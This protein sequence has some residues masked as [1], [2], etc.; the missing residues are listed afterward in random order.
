MCEMKAGACPSAGLGDRCWVGSMPAARSERLRCQ[1]KDL[2][3]WEKHAVPTANGVQPSPLQRRGAGA[4]FT[5]PTRV[6]G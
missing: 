1:M 3:S 4:A 6:P 5:P 2:L